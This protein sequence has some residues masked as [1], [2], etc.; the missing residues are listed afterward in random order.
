MHIQLRFW[1][2]S[3]QFLVCAFSIHS[4]LAFRFLVRQVKGS[5]KYYHRV[6]IVEVLQVQFLGT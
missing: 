2:S 6:N 5:K 4:V 1:S 3:N